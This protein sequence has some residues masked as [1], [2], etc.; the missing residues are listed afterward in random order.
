MEE[1]I[2]IRELARRSGVSVGTVS[3][4]L[5]GYT[6]VR[7][8]TRERIMRLASELDYTPAAAARS[9]VTQRSHVIGVFMETGEG[10]PDLQ[11]PFFHEVLGG[12]K[13][14]VGREGFDLL[15]FASE[16]PGGGYGRHSYLKRARHHNVDGCALIGLDPD[17][18]EVRRLARGEVPCVAIDMQL[19][20]P[21]TEVVMSDNEDGA[22]TAVRHLHDL[23]HR[24]IATITGMIDSRPGIDRLRGYRA[25]IQE[26]GLAYRDDYVRYGDFYAES[27]REQTARLLA[28][29]EPP[30][31]IF[32]AADM[33]AIGAVRAASEAGLNVPTDLSI[34]GFDD[35]QLAPHVNPPLTTL[36]QD[37][38]GLGAAA[39]DALVARIAGDPERPSLRTLPVE[40]VVRGSTAAPQ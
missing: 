28:L 33:M 23:G 37:K 40:L 19:E 16:R 5:N 13:Q 1:R 36:R 39:G 24:R 22:A 21:L 7:P 4:A 6:D 38:L 18:D 27:G 35:I 31:A 34:V 32:A 11:H 29:D 20:G 8:E 25:A 3:R 30:T 15:L 14:R 9:L 10:H 17:D 26:L 12:L 2:T